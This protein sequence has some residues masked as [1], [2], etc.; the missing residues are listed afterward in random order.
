MAIDLI[1]DEQVR[2]QLR[3]DA[4]E[5]DSDPHGLWIEIWIP[6]VSQAVSSW[7]KN[8]WRLYVPELDSEGAVVEDSNG[9]PIP[10]SVVHPL[11]IAACLYEIA[12]AFRFREGEGDNRVDQ[13]EGHGYVLS[14]TATAML[15]P[16][17]KPTV[18]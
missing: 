13:A 10:T 18:A 16:L 3:L 9:D 5:S 2:A 11:V 17:R 14:K 8:E 1:T 12:S 4:P 7:L 6:A 15:T